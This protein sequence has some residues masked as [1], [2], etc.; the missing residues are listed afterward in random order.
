MKNSEVV[1]ILPTYNESQNVG[2]V[3]EEIFSV[4][5]G[6]SILVVDDNSPDGTAVFVEE[7]RKKK[8]EQDLLLMKRKNKEGLGAAYLSAFQ[9]ILEDG[10]KKALIM[11]DADFSHHPKYLPEMIRLS[12]DYDVVVGSRYVDGGGVVGWESWRRLLSRWGNFYAKT[13]TGLPINDLTGGFNIIKCEF[14]RKINFSKFDASGYA[15]IIELK[16]LLFKK[17]ARVLE[18]P[19]VFSNRIRGESKISSHIIREGII[20]PWKI[21]FLS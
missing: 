6:I 10:E 15:F 8:Q 14:L 18:T 16:N 1:V 2:L 5:P 21:R 19:I 13:I 7:I 4:A 11:M 20:A 9:K 17:G 12:N 3:I